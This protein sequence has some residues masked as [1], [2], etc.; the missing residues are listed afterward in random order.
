MT[1]PK[2]KKDDRVLYIHPTTHKKSVAQVLMV[3][4]A[5][6]GETPAYDVM[7]DENVYTVPETWLRH[8]MSD[9]RLAREIAHEYAQA[10]YHL[11]EAKKALK[12]VRE[13]LEQDGQPQYE[14][15]MADEFG[16]VVK[17]TLR[18]ELNNEISRWDEI[19]DYRKKGV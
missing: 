15:T 5:V 12:K 3:N 6:V 8:L 10:Q 4:G 9:P 18:F 13:K 17:N 11:D 1:K 19:T 2:F 16:I 7:I 14:L